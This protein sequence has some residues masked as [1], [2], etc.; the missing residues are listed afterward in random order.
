MIHYEVLSLISE[1]SMLRGDHSIAGRLKA[2][3]IDA[4]QYIFY[5]NLRS[6]DRLNTTA[7]IR[8]QEEKSGVSYQE[9][10]RENAEELM[11]EA[12][13]TAGRGFDDSSSESSIEDGDGQLEREKL[14][15]KKAKFEAQKEANVHENKRDIPESQDTIA[16]N[17]MEGQK[18]V[19]QETWDGEE[20]QERQNYVTEQLYIHAKVHTIGVLL[21]KDCTCRLT[22]TG[23]H[24]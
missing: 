6:Y 13:A 21:N 9:L 20:E 10:Q 5:F 12:G 16:K 3:G 15:D 19:S 18:N 2:Q 8:R 17:A 4:N 11:G 24:R 7:E 22:T 14:H 1:R 23:S